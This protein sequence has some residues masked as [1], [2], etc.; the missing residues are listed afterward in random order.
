MAKKK[1]FIIGII[2]FF[3]IGF[4]Y[5]QYN[6]SK[7]PVH[8]TVPEGYTLDS[9]NIVEFLVVSCRKDGDCENPQVYSLMSDCPYVSLCLDNKCAVV[10]P[11]R[12]K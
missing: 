1:T 9:Y 10:C 8:P 5:S 11:D 2:I 7:K 12:K 4:A 6:S 3:A